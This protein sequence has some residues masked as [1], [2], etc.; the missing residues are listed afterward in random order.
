MNCAVTLKTMVSV[1]ENGESIEGAMKSVARD[2]YYIEKK[3]NDHLDQLLKQAGQP[4]PKKALFC[5]DAR[6]AKSKPHIWSKI[7]A[8]ALKF[9]LA[10]YGEKA[11]QAMGAEDI[12]LPYFMTKRCLSL[13]STNFG[14]VDHFIKTG[15]VNILHQA[16]QQH[17]LDNHSKQP[18]I[19]ASKPAFVINS[20]AIPTSFAISRSEN[21]NYSCVIL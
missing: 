4:V 2:A 11:L 7:D 12:R 14:R 16:L 20:L 6:L 10:E 9:E 18:V 19:G 5:N 8:L 21:Q 17:S 13:H 1:A 15:V 3:L